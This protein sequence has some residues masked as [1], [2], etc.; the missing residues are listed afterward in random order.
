MELGRLEV[1]RERVS[2]LPTLYLNV[3]RDILDSVST[4]D[5]TRVA[6]VLEGS[7][8]GLGFAGA[9]R[10]KQASSKLVA[11]KQDLKVTENDIK[12]RVNSLMTNRS[13]SAS[14]MLAQKESVDALNETLSSYMRQ[15]ESGRKS[16]L[17]VLNIQRELTE[18]RIQLAQTQSDWLV[19]S[20]R[21]ASLAGM[22]DPIAGIGIKNNEH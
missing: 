3:E 1:D 13:V 14:L 12:Q 15:Y 6:V 19:T 5:D 8:Q 11:A 22:L 16:W 21:V 17:E 9:S 4:T 2:D 18:Q 7:V 10:L 20:L